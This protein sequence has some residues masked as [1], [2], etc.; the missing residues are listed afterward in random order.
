VACSAPTITAPVE[1]AG[2]STTAKPA[3]SSGT[4]GQRTVQRSLI[5]DGSRRTYLAVGPSGQESGLPLLVVLHG[6]DIS[7]QQE[8][9]RT[10][11]LT[12]AEHGMADIIYPA[13]IG[14]SW[15]AGH[16]CCGVAGK[17]GVHD[18]TFVTE[19]VSDASKYFHSDS[20]RIYLV[21]YS[22]GAKLSFEEVCGH[23][24]MFAALA[25]YGAVPLAECSNPKP[26]SALIG[27]GTNDPLVRSER[28][29]L[30]ATAAVDQTVT[31]WRTRDTCTSSATTHSGPL[32]LTT[33][34]GCQGGTELAAALWS[35]VTHHWPT[36]APSAEPFTTPVGPQAAAATVMWTFLSRHSLG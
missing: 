26:I 25:T 16:G 30:S 6:R 8:S 2:H 28:S 33:S 7:A 3:V 22:N 9:Q 10:G 21:G 31:R 18:T 20:K 11:F 34:T 24:D 23:P 15:N 5:V 19:A 29:S 36:A 17:E 32:T 27:A 14:E 13:G 35:G 1:P 12:Y 4:A